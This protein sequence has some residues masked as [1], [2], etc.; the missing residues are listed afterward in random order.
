[1]VGVR[2]AGR[3]GEMLGVTVQPGGMAGKFG[4]MEQ[5]VIAAA[6]KSPKRRRCPERVEG[7][8]VF[9]PILY[10]QKMR[11]SSEV[12]IELCVNYNYFAQVSIFKKEET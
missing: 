10:W 6:S 8:A 9:I 7:R 4:K 11:P 2:V 5:A 1:M 12:V 3:V